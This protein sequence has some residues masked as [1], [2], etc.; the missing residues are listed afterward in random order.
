MKQP[1]RAAVVQ[2]PR[3]EVSRTRAV[4]PAHL[5]CASQALHRRELAPVQKELYHDFERHRQKGQEE[6][7][8]PR[9]ASSPP[10]S[11]AVVNLT[12]A[13]LVPS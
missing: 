6:H 12:L 10:L 13:S 7:Q 1:G 2:G 3:A 8:K 9:L 5:A 11:L 4:Q